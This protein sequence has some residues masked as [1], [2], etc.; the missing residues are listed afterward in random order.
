MADIDVQGLQQLE[1]ALLE[2]GA[3]LGFKT[4]RSAGRAAMKP[5]LE[6]AKAGAHV[7]S[8]DLVES[9][10][11][12][13]RRGKG[14]SEAVSIRVGPTKRSVRDRATKTSRKLTGVNQ[15][16]IAQEY[17]T[18]RQQAD[19]FLRPALDQNQSQVLATFSA[20]LAKKIDAAARKAAR[21]AIK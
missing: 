19:P 6:S 13:T 9:I 7:D 11:I 3:E 17:G 5:V 12:T 21:Q 8:G 10:A 4:L 15:K 1:H 14:R 20:E 18:R 16:A 2:L